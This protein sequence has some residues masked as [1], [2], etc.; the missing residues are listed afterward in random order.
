MTTDQ[1]LLL[2]EFHEAGIWLDGEL[3]P[4]GWCSIEDE[5]EIH[6]NTPDGCCDVC[7]PADQNL[8]SRVQQC[9]VNAKAL[10]GNRYVDKSH[11]FHEPVRQGPCEAPWNRHPPGGAP[12]SASWQGLGV[13]LVRQ[14][15]CHPALLGLLIVAIVLFI[16]NGLS[17][18]S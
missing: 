7:R 6:P 2:E 18:A 17:T 14:L 11:G 5:P 16:L 4:L 8:W 13:A 1:D 3:R 12:W 15:Y 10:E 9:V